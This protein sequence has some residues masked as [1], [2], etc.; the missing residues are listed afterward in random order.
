MQALKNH[1]KANII[2]ILLIFQC[3]HTIAQTKS[4]TTSI[5]VQ[6]GL[7]VQWNEINVQHPIVVNSF[8]NLGLSANS[9]LYRRDYEK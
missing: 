5:E 3:L 6:S 2:M 9:I 7:H 1:H 8:L 4:Y